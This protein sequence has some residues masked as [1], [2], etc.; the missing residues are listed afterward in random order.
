MALKLAAVLAA[1]APFMA[2][3]HKPEEL[4]A[5]I[6]AADKGAKDKGG[7]DGKMPGNVGEAKEIEGKDK[8]AKDK[9]AKDEKDDMDAKD[10]KDDMDAKDRDDDPE[11]TND[12]DIDTEDEDLSDG[13]P[14]TPGGNR[15][16]GAKTA[17][18]SAEV[19]RRIAAAV[20]ARDSLH[21]ALRE[22][23][24][25]LG[26][27]TFDSAPKAYRAALKHLGID[28]A[29]VHSSALPSMLKLA[30]DKASASSPAPAMDSAGLSAL[31]K[32]IPGYSR[33]R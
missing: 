8:G 19:D 1:I 7:K 28:T 30:K 3:D 16:G 5:A 23:E 10:E 18:D 29:G 26:R 27:V 33:L 13:D 2:A 32:V 4:K 17:V 14:S 20:G 9:G 25:V 15:A 6:I 22:V 12:K 21:T 11:H 31:D 24:P